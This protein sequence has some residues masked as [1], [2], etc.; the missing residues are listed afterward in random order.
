MRD[1][2]SKRPVR[3][4]V[5]VAV[6][7]IAAMLIPCGFGLGEFIGVAK[8]AFVSAAAE[9]IEASGARV[10]TSQLAVIT[11]L[12]RA[13]VAEI[14][15]NSG[16]PHQRSSPPPT[17]RVMHAWFNDPSFLTR[18]GA[19]AALRLKGHPSFRTLVSR[20]AGDV[21]P[22][23]VMRELIAGGMAR[24]SGTNEIHAI[25]RYRQTSPAFDVD[26]ERAAAAIDLLLS[27]TG[28]NKP[29][30]LASIRLVNV[31]FSGRVPIGV[32]RTVAQRIERFL[33][34]LSEYLHSTEGAT[35]PALNEVDDS[36]VLRFMVLQN[37]VPH[38][39]QGPVGHQ[40]GE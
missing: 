23:A 8:E 37:V 24:L 5:F 34:A 16:A 26:F 25:S 19:P 2:A 4:F 22:N 31:R 28:I 3:S 33:D 36:E 21:T 27:T 1:P 12:S 29:D 9:H 20:S 17:E 14:R 10:S 32:R 39:P 38:E 30:S 7:R 6:R 13:E 15:R 11:G 18:T 40:H 35:S